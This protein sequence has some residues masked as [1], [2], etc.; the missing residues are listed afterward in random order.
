MSK[1]KYASPHIRILTCGVGCLFSW[2]GVFHKITSHGSA[3]TEE[4]TDTTAN[5]DDISVDENVLWF[6][7]E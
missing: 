6:E 5:N 1:N 2:S 7:E 4:V 3:K